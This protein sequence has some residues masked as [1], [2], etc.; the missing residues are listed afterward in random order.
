[1]EKKKVLVIAD[2]GGCPPHM[3]YKSLAEKFYVYSYVPRPFALTVGHSQLMEQYSVAVLKDTDFL[4]TVEDY[5]H[6]TSIYWADGE[7]T[8][9]ERQ[10]ADDIKRVARLFEVDAI[11]TNNELFVVPMAIACEELGLRGAGSE[12]AKRSRDKNLMRESFNASGV[13]AIKSRRVTTLADFE[14]GLQEVGLPAIL[15][16]SYLASSIGVRKIDGSVDPSQLFLEVQEQLKNIPVPDSVTFEAPF[17]L[18][19]F[20]EGKGDDWY[21]TDGLGDYVSIE[22]L[23]VDGTYYPLAITDKGG[24]IPPFI[25]TTQIMPT[26]L[27]A[28]ARAIIVDTARKACEGLGLQWCATH[29]EI[30]LM[31]NR[32]AGVIESAARFPG[33]N[34]IPQIKTTFGVDAPQLLVEL[35]CNGQSDLLPNTLLE[36]PIRSSGNVHLFLS[37]FRD[38]LEVDG[39]ET[40]LLFDSIEIPEELLVGD[41]QITSFSSLGKGT[42]LNVNDFFEVLHS[43]AAVDLISSNA[44]DMRRSLLNIRTRSVLKLTP[45]KEKEAQR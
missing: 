12:A 17:I 35:L 23:M 14:A 9:S 11:T 7:F 37:D 3:F 44:E 45:K 1:M 16:P 36:E 28:E 13:A 4:Q 34:V 39:D 5:E 18:E 24:L 6:P 42:E 40:V 25:E 29:T 31:K 2:L 41:T 19:T 15:K 30:K 22:G 21:D 10:V 26:S 38:Q 32:Q 33:W 20:L 27:D 43:V 8:K